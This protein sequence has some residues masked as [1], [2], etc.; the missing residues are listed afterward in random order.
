MASSSIPK[1]NSGAELVVDYN[2]F[3]GWQTDKRDLRNLFDSVG[4]VSKD[5]NTH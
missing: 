4:L 3:Q 2:D 1:K 5:E